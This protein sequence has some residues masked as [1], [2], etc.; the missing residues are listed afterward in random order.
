VRKTFASGD[1]ESMIAWLGE[2][3]LRHDA[4]RIVLAYEASGQGFGL[5]DRLTDAGIECY[6]LALTHLPHTTHRRK[7]KTDDKDAEM[8]LD[9]VRGYVL[10]GR[11][12]PTVDSRSANPR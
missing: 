3:A 8:L 5:Y 11:K 9:E 6:V 10:A 12:L 7:N 4:P 1:V 2:F